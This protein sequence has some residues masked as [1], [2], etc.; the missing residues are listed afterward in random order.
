[1]K[2]SFRFSWSDTIVL[3]HHPRGDGVETLGPVEGE[4]PDSAAQLE[5]DGLE[6]LGRVHHGCPV[7]DFIRLGAWKVYPKPNG[8][9]GKLYTSV[10]PCRVFSC[11]RGEPQTEIPT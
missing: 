6:V 11:T 8:A 10:C 5:A 3:V 2:A 9:A 4:Q 1:M 7:I